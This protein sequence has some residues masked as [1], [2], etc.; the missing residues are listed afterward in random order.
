MHQLLNRRGYSGDDLLHSWG[1]WLYG[2]T[3]A[4][5]LTLGLCQ[6]APAAEVKEAGKDAGKDPAVLFLSA[7][8]ESDSARRESLVA[9]IFADNGIMADSAVRAV[10]H[11]AIVSRIETVQRSLPGQIFQQIGAPQR[12][13]DAWRIAYEVVDKTGSTSYEGLMFALT[14]P[15]GKFERVDIFAGPSAVPLP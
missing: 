7:L 2:V 6:P 9:R 8:N 11:K 12:Q 3:L 5:V 10:G 13:H 15:D 14:Q 1:Q 4:G